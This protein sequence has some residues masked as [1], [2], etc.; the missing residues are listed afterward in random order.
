[1][2]ERA[3][4]L[5]IPFGG[6]PGN[7]NAITDVA[8]VQVGFSTLCQGEPGGDG[9]VCRTGV[10]AILP[11]G[12]RRSAVFAGR[13]DLNGNGELTGTHWV[14]DSG[15]LH[16]PILITNTNSVGIVRDAA[17]Q[18]MLEN[19]FFYPSIVEGKEVPGFGFFYPVVGETYDGMLNDINRFQVREEDALWALNTA[20]SGPVAEGNVGGGTG[21]RC[22]NFKGGTG[23]AS[24]MMEIEGVGSYTLGVLVQANFGLRED[25]RI[26]GIPFGREIHGCDEQ[27]VSRAVKDGEGSVIVIAATDAPILPWQ[28]RRLCRRI[29]VGIGNMGGGF[30]NGSGDIFLAF[31]TANEGAYAPVMSQ[32]TLLSDEKIEPLYRAVAQATEEAVANALIAARSMTGRNGNYTPAIPHDQVRAIIKAYKTWHSNFM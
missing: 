8:G 7:Y 32:I 24:R 18:W 6:T 29:S 1:M 28:L 12:R 30:Q 9:P 27:I 31:S 21:M 2:T 23:T 22:F 5:G 4:D 17:A 15:F 11:R 25:L 20:A 14:D 26:A 3:R 19:D 16:G 13:H 10:T